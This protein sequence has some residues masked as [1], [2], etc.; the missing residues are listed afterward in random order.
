MKALIF[1][2]VLLYSSFASADYAEPV[3][4]EATHSHYDIR[5]QIIPAEQFIKVSGS[6]MYLVHQDSLR[7]ISVNLHKNLTLSKFTVNGDES[8]ELDT[9]KSNTRWLPD[10]VKIFHTTEKNYSEGDIVKIEFSYDGVI[11]EWP[12]WSANVI[13][14]DWI[15][16]GLYFPWYPTVDGLFTYKVAVDIDPGYNVFAMG[17]MYRKGNN[18]I[19]ENDVPVYDLVIC[20]SKDLTISSTNLLSNAFKIVNSSLSK[21]IVDSIQTDIKKTYKNYSRWFGNIDTG[22]MCLV[23]SKRDKG[24]GYSRKNGLYLGGLSDSAYIEDRADFLRY[25]SH[26]IAHFWWNGAPGN[27]EDWLNESF[28]EYSAMKIVKELYGEEEFQK[29]LNIKINNSIDTPPVWGLDRNHPKAEPVLYSKGTV[30]LYEL[31]N[32]M[33]IVGFEELCKARLNNDVKNSAGLLDLID[34][35]S[36]PETAIWFEQNLKTR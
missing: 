16:I 6:L 2:T 34:K 8:Y 15:E 30:L 4:K 24:G 20:A 10:A 28:A 5:L 32:K 26:E 22:D 35:I 9:S 36:G 12:E 23:I 25:V 3:R 13:T 7:S 18:T 14:P 21:N 1:F 29:I 31:E 27:W 17:D 11:N 33:G 19:I